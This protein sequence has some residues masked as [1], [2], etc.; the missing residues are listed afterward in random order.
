MKKLLWLCLSVVL[1]AAS[2]KN[3]NTSA[4]RIAV[5][6]KGASA[7]FWKSIHAGA[8]KAAQE[9]GV[10]VLWKGPLKDDDLKAQIDVVQSF[11][12]QGVSGITLAPLSDK[13][14]S[15]AV[16][17][18]VAAKIP[19]IVFDSDLQGKD[20]LSFIATDNYVGGKLGGEEL[21]RL[22]GGKGKV[23]MMRYVEGSAS[24]A[25]RE[26]GFLDVMKQN[27]GIEVVSENQHG[28]ATTESAFKSAENLLAATKAAAGG[29]DGIFTVAEATTLG[30]LLALDKAGLAGKLKFIGFDTSS[31]L[32]DGVRQGQI[33]GLVVQNP[34]KMGYLAVTKMTQH[35]RGEKVEPYIDTGVT[36]VTQKNLDEPNIRE[37]VAPDLKKWLRE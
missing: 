22:L 30:M 27:P 15:G 4:T 25:K 26:Q 18:A 37:L 2:C 7:E 3:E 21:V 36:L 5:I 6:P 14:L 23:L 20:H 9:L 11:T 29:V 35:L 10:E 19:V 33:H 31:K 32:V 34:F 17:Q 8:E 1:L 24:T 12:A 16:K 28:G 13:G